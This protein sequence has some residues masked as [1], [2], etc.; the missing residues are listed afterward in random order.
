MTASSSAYSAPIALDATSVVKALAAG[1]EGKVS[2]EIAAEY[3][4]S[5]ATGKPVKYEKLYSDKYPATG[6]SSLT[7]GLKGTLTFGDLRWQGFKGE[8]ATVIVDLGKAMS[9]RKASVGGLQETGSWIMMPKAAEISTSL[10]GETFS[11]AVTV[12]SDVDP[13]LSE[14]VMKH[15]AAEFAPRQARYVRVNV[16]NFGALPV[17]HP[18]AGNAS[19]LFVDEVLVY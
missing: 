5:L 14:T 11:P 7:N 18:G 19:W 2:P 8:D 3:H 16:K 10:D 13:K 9:V 15:F 6:P 17:G 12:Q 4:V 1:D